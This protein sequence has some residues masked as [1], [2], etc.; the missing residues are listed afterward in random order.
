MFN[1]AYRHLAKRGVTWKGRSYG[2]V[3]LLP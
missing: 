1:S 2:E 3:D